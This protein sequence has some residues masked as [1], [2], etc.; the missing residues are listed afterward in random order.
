M[1]FRNWRQTAG[2][3]LWASGLWAQHA[4]TA[5]LYFGTKMYGVKYCLIFCCLNNSDNVYRP[6]VQLKRCR[7]SLLVVIRC[8]A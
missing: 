8:I 7:Q 6:T 1:I 5:P 3:D 4:F 2:F